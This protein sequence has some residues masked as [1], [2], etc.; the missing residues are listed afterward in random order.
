ML[1]FEEFCKNIHQDSSYEFGDLLEQI[2]Y[3]TAANFR[4]HE[5]EG[6]LKEIRQF[7]SGGKYIDAR[8]IAERSDILLLRKKNEKTD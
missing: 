7:L 2:V 3:G 8:I 4:K 1:T 5:L 6:L